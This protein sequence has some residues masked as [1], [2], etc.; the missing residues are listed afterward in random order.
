MD[1]A[2]RLPY[3]PF[4]HLCIHHKRHPWNRT[5]SYLH[6]PEVNPVPGYGYEDEIEGEWTDRYD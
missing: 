2:E 5:T 1:Q 6:N 4:E 3:I